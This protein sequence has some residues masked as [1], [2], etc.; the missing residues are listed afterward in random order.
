MKKVFLMLI[1]F[2]ILAVPTSAQQGNKDERFNFYGISFGMKRE[3]VKAVRGTNIDATEVLK[4]GH[5]MMF[6][7]LTYDHEDR[8]MVIRASYQRPD[9]A[10]AQAGLRE[11]LREKFLK[12]V[13]TGFRNISADIDEYSNMAA[14]MIVLTDLG[15]R[16]GM[17][18][19]YREEALKKME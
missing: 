10:Y 16:Q 4:P 12:P 13:S 6:L 2:C 1:L 11:A 8:L 17:I 19:H 14:F 5:G 18:D 3:E 15:L 9:D 7:T